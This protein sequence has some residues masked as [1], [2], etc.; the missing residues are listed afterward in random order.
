MYVRLAL[1]KYSKAASIVKIFDNLF[2]TSVKKGFID[3]NDGRSLRFLSFD[4]GT[5]F[6]HSLQDIYS[7]I[8]IFYR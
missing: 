5:G 6:A 3:W 2:I 7:T 1:K 8:M 4:R